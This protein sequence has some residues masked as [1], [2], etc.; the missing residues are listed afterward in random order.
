M[1]I[2]SSDSSARPDSARLRQIGFLPLLAL[3]YAY[4]ASGPFGYEEIFRS[5]GPGMAFL[6]LAIVPFFWSVPI[7]FAAAELNGM[8]PVQCGW[9]NWTGT[10][11]LN[12]VYGVLVMDYII[13]YI[14][15]TPIEKW[16]GAAAV[17]ILIVWLNVRGI[18]VA[19]WVGTALQAAI[20][21]PVVW[22]CVVA[23]AHW[24]FNPL[25]P[26]APP[27]KPFHA[28]FGAGLALAMW[29]YAGY[30]QLSVIAQ[31]IKDEQKT[32]LRVLFWNT[33]LNIITYTLPATLA[34]AA[35]GNWA[36]WQTGYIVTASRLIGGPLLGAAMLVA[37]VLANLSL[38]N[39]TV[40]YTTRIPAAMAEDGYLPRWLSQIHP[41]FGTPARVIVVSAVIYCALAGW[42]VVNL[43]N[44]YIW[45]RI[46]TSILTVLAAWRLRS[47]WPN[48]P[49]RFR[50][51]W[52]GWGMAYVLIPVAAL[53]A[54]KVANSEP[55]VFRW[56]PALLAAGP[57]AYL[58]FRWVFHLVPAAPVVPPTD[59]F[60]AAR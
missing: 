31:E 47:K 16:A 6:F 53:C 15:M 2:S 40:L 18:Q 37:S 59:E 32:F 22:L 24:H 14:P 27:G 11:L 56:G 28:V 17:L 13:D 46:A 43:V 7:S 48:A 20:L 51:P 49:R 4:T 42:P 44:I 50:I 9:W 39:S 21:L 3:F 26:L 38:S 33:P 30:E 41:R 19:G 10:F 12:T 1:S 5:S 29:N 8:L 57:M 45:T 36:M 58:I 34:L 23:V 54:L 25:A 52:Q 55:Y 60:G 35:L